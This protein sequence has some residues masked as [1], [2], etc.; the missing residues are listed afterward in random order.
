[1]ASGFPGTH[2]VLAAEPAAARE[3]TLVRWTRLRWRIYREIKTG[4]A[5]TTTKAARGKAGTTT[6]P[7][8]P[9]PTPS[10]PAAPGPDNPCAGLTLYAVLRGLQDVLAYLIGTCPPAE[11]ASRNANAD[12]ADTAD[13]AEDHDEVL[14]ALFVVPGC[15][16]QQGPMVL[17]ACTP[18][19]PTL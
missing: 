12:T 13:T 7:R 4:L 16:A 1:V 3:T 10:G 19:V 9:P 14:P 6:S 11:P 15:P 5:W 2:Q 17:A 18:E 8:A